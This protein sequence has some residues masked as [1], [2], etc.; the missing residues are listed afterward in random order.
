[1]ADRTLRGNTGG[2]RSQEGLPRCACGH[3]E[4]FHR[5][6]GSKKGTSGSCRYCSCLKV[7]MPAAESPRQE[8]AGSSSS[9]GL[10]G[11]EGDALRKALRS[12]L[13]EMAGA[14]FDLLTTAPSST[15]PHPSSTVCRDAECSQ[16]APPERSEAE[17]AGLERAR[18][19]TRSIDR[20]CRPGAWGSSDNC[21]THEGLPLT[22]GKCIDSPR[23]TG[24]ENA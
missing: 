5:A 9:P 17:Q 3:L 10:I 15:M 16:C 24:G 18:E 4:E 11:A 2:R 6:K 1:M 19:V 23:E 20:A 21:Q 14:A 8:P 12:E 22:D 7:T 13:G